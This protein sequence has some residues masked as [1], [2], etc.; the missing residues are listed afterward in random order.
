M[1]N[2]ERYKAGELLALLTWHGTFLTHVHV[3]DVLSHQ[4]LDLASGE[5]P[6]LLLDRTSLESRIPTEF[7]LTKL[8]SLPMPFPKL[9]LYSHNSSFISFKCTNGYNL[10]PDGKGHLMT[11]EE[12]TGRIYMDREVEKE[13]E[14]FTPL[15]S[16][17]VSGLSILLANGRLTSQPESLSG[18]FRLHTGATVACGTHLFPINVNRDLLLRIGSKNSMPNA[19]LSLKCG[20]SFIQDNTG[21]NHEVFM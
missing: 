8:Y 5:Q 11:A 12:N 17:L 20:T 18:N 10:Y 7:W 14:Q 9:Q 15:S 2:L 6:N 21:L 16:Q 19:N 13:W 4:P 3:G 1:S